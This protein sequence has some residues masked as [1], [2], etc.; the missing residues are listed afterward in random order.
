[1]SDIIKTYS[2]DG[3]TITHPSGVIVTETHD[4]L[5]ARVEQLEAERTKTEEEIAAVKVDIEAIE[6]AKLKG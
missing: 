3:V 5:L 4:E 2:A 1:M 6:I